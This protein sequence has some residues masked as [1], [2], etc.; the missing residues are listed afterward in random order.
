MDDL[1]PIEEMTAV[2]P[3]HSGLNVHVWISAKGRA[4]HGPR[5]KIS[6][7]LGRFDSDDNFSMTVSHNPQIVTGQ[8]KV[9][10]DHLETIK[11]W[12]ILNHDHLH[13]IWHSDT[14][15]SH[16]HLDGIIKL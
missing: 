1:I 2:A 13:K 11:D 6:N 4:K 8:A 7:T 12:I 3:R 16:D 9:K 5:I 15:D 10:Q 14:M